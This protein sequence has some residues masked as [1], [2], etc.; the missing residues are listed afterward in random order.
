MEVVVGI[1][2]RSNVVVVSLGIMW[3]M[4]FFWMCSK[5]GCQ[6]WV[7]PVE[8]VGPVNETISF[9]YPLKHLGGNR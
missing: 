3:M 2:V 1:V 5:G 8:K 6:M 7:G 9:S 4:D